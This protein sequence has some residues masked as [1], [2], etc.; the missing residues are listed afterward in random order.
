MANQKKIAKYRKLIIEWLKDVE[1]LE[2]QL[3]NERSEKKIKKLEEKLDY[4]KS[5]VIANGRFLGKQGGDLNDI[6]SLLSPRQQ[7]IINELFSYGLNADDMIYREERRRIIDRHKKKIHKLQEAYDKYP[8]YDPGLPIEQKLESEIYKLEKDLGEDLFNESDKENK[9][10]YSKDWNY[11]EHMSTSTEFTLEEREIMDRCY[12]I[13]KEYHESG[14][15]FT[16]RAGEWFIN[17]QAKSWCKK[18]YTK[19]FAEMVKYLNPGRRFSHDELMRESKEMTK[20]FLEFVLDEELLKQHVEMW[21]EL[22]NDVSLQGYSKEDRDAIVVGKLSKDIGI[23]RA[24]FTSAYVNI[25]DGRERAF[26]VIKNYTYE[27]LGL[28]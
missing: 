8:P 3:Q 22:Y 17:A 21:N 12:L 2:G 20:R 18:L 16:D 23:E 7:A 10:L 11:L 19:A 1:K 4:C 15:S 24:L 25:E 26:D 6:M 14:L 13:G 27:E 5:M 28:E 9:V